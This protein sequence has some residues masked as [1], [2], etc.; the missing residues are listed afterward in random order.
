MARIGATLVSALAL[1]ALGAAIAL[2]AQAEATDG[3][4]D[5]IWSDEFDGVTG[6]AP[7]AAK[8]THDTGFGWGSGAELQAYTDRTKNAALDGQGNLAIT[9]RS[10]TYTGPDGKTSGYTSARLNTR[11]KFSH[12][13]GRIEA[14][15]KVPSGQG[16]WPAFWLLGDDVFTTGWPSC[17]EIDM[18]EVLGDD[19]NVLYQSI[20]GP[21]PEAGDGEF[22]LTERIEFTRPLSAGF[23]VYGAQ[24]G[25]GRISLTA[26]GEVYRTFSPADLPPGARWVFDHPHHLILNVAVGGDWPGPPDASTPFPATML[27]DWVRVWDRDPRGTAARFSGRADLIV[28]DRTVRPRLACD[29][30]AGCRG[31]TVL[32]AP[33]GSGDGRAVLGRRS[34]SI[35]AGTS[36]RTAIKLTRRGS[37][38]LA[39]RPNARAKIVITGASG[40]S[41]SRGVT[42]RSKAQA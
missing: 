22:G 17:G 23:H 34:Y 27:V 38:L 16:I 7:D 4:Q 15:I 9:A 39:E 20:H 10:E 5:L 11:K 30:G 31:R 40:E 19:P 12:V 28:R 26:D 2:P 21:Q 8:W 41:D 1:L 29:G 33:V 25:P 3:G 32:T 35:G 36:K 13:Y 18:M 6:S 24:W 37:K 14:R 42:L